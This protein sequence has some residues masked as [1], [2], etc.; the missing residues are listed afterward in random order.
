[1]RRNLL[2]L[3]GL[4]ATFLLATLLFMDAATFALAKADP[5]TGRERGCYTE[6]ALLLGAK[7]ASKWEWIRY[8]ELAIAGLLLVSGMTVLIQRRSSK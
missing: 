8:A 5:T 2:F 7:R 1:M 4:A 3:L 6:L